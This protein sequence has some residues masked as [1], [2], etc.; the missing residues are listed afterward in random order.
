V[1]TT[2]R[3]AAR[4]T[5]SPDHPHE[6][7]DDLI[8]ACGSAPEYGPPPRAWGR[9][10]AHPAGRRTRRTTPTSV[11]TTAAPPNGCR[12]AT[13]HPHERGDDDGTKPGLPVVIGPPPRAWGRRHDRHPCAD[14]QRTTPT[15]VGT[16]TSRTPSSTW[17][18]D[19]PH[20]RGDDED[21]NDDLPGDDGPPPRA[22][23]RRRHRPAHPD[24][25]RTTPRAWGRQH[26]P[27]YCVNEVRTTP[28]S[29]GTTPG[30]LLQLA[31]RPDHP[32]ERGDDAA[33]VG[34]VVRPA[35]PPPR[36]W[37]RRRPAGHHPRQRR[38]T[39]TS[40]GTTATTSRSSA[41]STDHPHERGDDRDHIE[42]VGGFYGPPPRAWGRPDGDRHD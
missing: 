40:V 26:R 29:V 17:A 37:G 11:G 24:E 20:E 1:G 4:S 5:A 34:E 41:G 23:G 18:A 42:V 13:D 22:W 2:T 14:R 21:H 7:G 3:G 32:H 6:R 27:R 8:R 30:R 36:A 25:Q 9:R 10:R 38:T 33:H 35:G 12:W 28:T 39:P 16:T 19:H 15:S 31:P